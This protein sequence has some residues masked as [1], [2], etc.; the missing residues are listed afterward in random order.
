M[1]D[2]FGQQVATPFSGNGPF[3]ANLADTL[4]G[5]DAL[6]SLR[7]RGESLRPFE[8]VEDIR[9]NADA[10]YRQTERQLT[11]KLEETEKRLRELRQGTPARPA[12]SA[13]RTRP[14]S[15][16][17]SGPRSTG[18]GRRSSPPAASSAPCSSSCAATSRGWRPCCG[19]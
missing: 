5:S 13:T 16:R 19:W 10:E 6:I 14:S 12:P 18:R 2:F 11:Q 9:R 7:S 1:Q 15:P 4:S 3:L 17:S 8:L